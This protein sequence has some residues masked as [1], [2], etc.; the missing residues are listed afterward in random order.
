MIE[1][2]YREEDSCNDEISVKLPKNIKQIG[3]TQ[4][5]LKV[6]FEEMVMETIKEKARYGVLLGYIKRMGSCSYVF[7]NSAVLVNFEESRGVDFS[8][9]VWTGIH[10]D[11][12]EYY[13]K[14]EI[15]GWF[16]SEKNRRI[17]SDKIR[18]I[19]L[20]NFP[21]NDKI[22]FLNDIS[23][24]EESVYRYCN[25]DMEKVDGYYIYFDKNVI[26]EKYLI[27]SRALEE[28][29][30]EEVKTQEI[31]ETK[32][33]V[34]EKAAGF[35]FREMV[36]SYMVIALLLAIIV[37]MNNSNQINSVK[38]SLSEIA[39]NL[40]NTPATGINQETKVQPVMENLTSG[41][42]ENKENEV[43]QETTTF[44][45]EQPEQTT[46]L[47]T[48]KET[49]QT[50]HK[51]EETTVNIEPVAEPV[52]YTIKKGE[53]L[54]DISRSIYNNVAMVDTI[55]KANDIED[56]DKVYEG[57]KIVLP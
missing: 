54:S 56:P 17:A 3:D 29:F 27:R 21:G 9:K 48:K 42:T 23:E 38:S 13:D 26:F 19:H 44:Q 4:G 45:K 7:V 8:D 35:N 1:I 46:K 49:E 34:K 25:G 5:N 20:D 11:I 14:P 18:R 52:F 12:K 33:L 30:E 51:Q 32:P 22:C 47:E 57:Q 36:S 31:K 39:G 55:M 28:I 37:V 53:T 50:T 16:V 10:E 15:V 41:T 43:T 2:V 6:Y 24:N 40:V